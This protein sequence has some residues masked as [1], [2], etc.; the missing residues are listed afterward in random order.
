[1][2]RTARST[3][4]A[5]PILAV[6]AL[7]LALAGCAAPAPGATTTPA[8]EA[9]A[10]GPCEQVSVVVDFGPLDEASIAAC[11]AAGPALDVLDEAGIATEG[12]ADYGNAVVCRVNNAPAP[13]ETVEL[14]GEA[15]FTESCAT[16]NSAAYWALWVKNSPDGQWEYAQSG[17][18]ALE[19]ADGQSVGLVYTPGT[20][21]IPPQD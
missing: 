8:P 19:L 7:A 10:D 6:A 14:E 17:V 13:D 4:T 21:S 2:T 18:D 3:R 11:A 12:T 1:M 16:L 20:E 9:T 5:W 15:P